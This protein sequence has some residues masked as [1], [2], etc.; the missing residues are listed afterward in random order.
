MF[1]KRD[2]KKNSMDRSIT[3]TKWVLR[4]S[5]IAIIARKVVHSLFVSKE[6]VIS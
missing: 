1:V 2:F 6:M 3:F 4:R 5:S